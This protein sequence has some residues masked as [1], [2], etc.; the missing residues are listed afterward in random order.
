MLAPS[1]ALSIPRI[2]SLL[3]LLTLCIA[4]AQPAVPSD[5]YQDARRVDGDRLVFCLWGGNPTME[6]DRQ[7]GNAIAESLF[8]EVGFHT[9][10]PVLANNEEFWEELFLALADECVALLGFR[11][12]PVTLPEWVTVTRPYY[13]ASHV[14]AVTNPEVESLA[15]LP[16]DQFVGSRLFTLA[17]QQFLAYLQALPADQR[18]SRLP[19]TSNEHQLTYLLEGKIGGAIAWAPAVHETVSKLEDAGD[20]PVRYSRLEPLPEIVTEVGLVL[21]S[22][23]TYLRQ[24]FDDS[25]RYLVEAGIIQEII[26]ALSY[27]GSP[28]E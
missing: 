14:L 3:L 19:F 26:E 17:D 9:L 24:T 2:S 18:W 22:Q 16:R 13:K 6:L 11:L 7:V 12:E 8:L 25:I 1:N 15:D 27:P 28:A 23:D 10:S 21:R 5:F 4:L 20:T